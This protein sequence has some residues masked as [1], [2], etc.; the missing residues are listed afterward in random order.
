MT[1]LEN[2]RSKLCQTHGAEQS[3]AEQNTI[4]WCIISAAGVQSNPDPAA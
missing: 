4:H 1:Q 3:W 2:I